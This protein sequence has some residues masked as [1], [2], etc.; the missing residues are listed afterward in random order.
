MKILDICFIIVI[1][2]V[3]V[4]LI[5]HSTLEPLTNEQSLTDETK[6]MCEKKC[7]KKCKKKKDNKKCI[8]CNKKCA[9]KQIWIKKH[10]N[11]YVWPKYDNRKVTHT[12]P[13]VLYWNASGDLSVADHGHESTDLNHNM[14]HNNKSP[15]NTVTNMGFSIFNRFINNSNTTNKKKKKIQDNHYSMPMPYDQTNKDIINIYKDGNKN[16]SPVLF[17][18]KICNSDTKEPCTA[19]LSGNENVGYLYPLNYKNN[20]NTNK[21]NTD[22]PYGDYI[23]S[24]LW[25]NGVTDTDFYN[26][27]KHTHHWRKRNGLGKAKWKINKKNKKKL[28]NKKKARVT[29]AN[30]YMDDNYNQNKDQCI[31]N[32]TLNSSSKLY[33]IL[34]DG[35]KITDSNTQV[36]KSGA[37]NLVKNGWEICTYDCKNN[38][39]CVC[40]PMNA[41]GNPYLNC[42]GG[43]TCN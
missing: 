40:G 19:D 7:K 26:G 14:P 37:T 23:H 9:K 42:K 13:A 28:K 41:D 39:C 21:V 3:I 36:D 34:K 38:A 16:L 25:D 12:H 11:E 33:Q 10:I 4:I 24:L 32:G 22:A 2:I 1:G 6:L 31:Y 17:A 43:G 35:K 29:D 5:N 20:Y 30:K 27:K 15:Y 8:K 18:S